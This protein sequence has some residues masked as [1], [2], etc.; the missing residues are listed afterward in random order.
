MA[1]AARKSAQASRQLR[2]RMYRHGLG[3]CF[4]LTVPDAKGQPFHIM[5]DCGV[6]LGTENIN[7]RLGTVLD[8]VI[9]TTGGNLDVLIVTHEHFDHVAA[10]SRLPEKF[11]RPGKPEAG[12]RQ[13]DHSEGCWF[14]R[15]GARI[16]CDAGC[17]AAQA[18]PM[19]PRP[20]RL[21]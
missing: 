5:I 12:K 8:D 13:T 1:R 10:F 6:I 9:K 20:P 16:G 19:R 4:L 15:N 17:E 3:D 14:R 2:I 18:V 21:P 11:A 7:G